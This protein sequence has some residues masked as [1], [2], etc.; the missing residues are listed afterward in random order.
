MNLKNIFKK[1]SPLIDFI[2]T[3]LIIPSAFILKFY[4]IYGSKRLKISSNLLEYVRLL[5]KTERQAHSISKLIR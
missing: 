4:R 2:L 1:F 5:M 3:F